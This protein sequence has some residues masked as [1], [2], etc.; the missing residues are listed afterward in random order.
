MNPGG[1][2]LCLLL[3]DDESFRG[4]VNPGGGSLFLLL[5]FKCCPFTNLGGENPGGASVEGAVVLR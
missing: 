2:S 4:G 5:E 1:G 3:S